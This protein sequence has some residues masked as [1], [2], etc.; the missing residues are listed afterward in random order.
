MN[1]NEMVSVPRKPTP[2][3]LEA[4]RAPCGETDD[5]Y[6]N[7][8]TLEE[9][10]M[11][12]INA[13]P[14]EQHQGEPVGYVCPRAL[15]A[16]INGRI[17]A[18][19]ISIL[20]APNLYINK[21][22]YTHAD[23]GE[24]ERWKSTAE[25]FTGVSIKATEEV[26][27][28][29]AQLAERDA[30]LNLADHALSANSFNSVG[31][32]IEHDQAMRDEVCAKI[33]ALYASAE[34]SA[35]ECKHPIKCARFDN[36]EIVDHVCQDCLH[37]FKPSAPVGLD[38]RECRKCGSLTAEKCKAGGCWFER[39]PSAPVERD[40]RAGLDVEAAAQRLAACMDYPWEFMP[41]QGRN[42]M[43]EHAKAVINAAL[44]RKPSFE[45][46]YNEWVDK[47]EWARKGATPKE[48]G[49]HLADVI[50]ARYEQLQADLT[51]RDE[52][53][54]ALRQGMKGDYD[55]DAWLAFVEEAPQL[56]KDAERYRWLRSR[57][58]NAISQGGV[59][60]GL[61]PDNLVLNE[62][63]LDKAIDAAMAPDYVEASPHGRLNG[64]PP[65]PCSGCGTP[66]W[67]GNCP[68]CIPY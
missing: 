1:S 58:L 52:E 66:G 18:E 7:P 25:H 20:K 45:A 37:V 38:P 34:P 6:P 54:D 30:L 40:E 68:Q 42:S 13:A 63:T 36:G 56:R 12:A 16:A 44:E 32:V 47:S 19:Q 59:F 11:A 35:P 60:A 3:M 2:A 5:G 24:V 46:A 64:T 51:A 55:L 39:E 10:Y 29:R 15:D 23:P 50:R 26:S 8:A 57:D 14:A 61:T 17:G 65:E 31:D 53:I 48:L 28:L 9:R 43:R 21:P 41:E 33:A 62:E 49:L 4:M 27:R 22:L 67:T